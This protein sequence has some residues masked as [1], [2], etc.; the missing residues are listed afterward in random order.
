MV[1]E[2]TK[3]TRIHKKWFDTNVS[4]NTRP[5]FFL[6]RNLIEKEEIQGESARVENMTALKYRRVSCFPLAPASG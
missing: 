5:T 3:I 6:C 1:V 4:G 2:T